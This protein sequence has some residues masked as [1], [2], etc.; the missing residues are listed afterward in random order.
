VNDRFLIEVLHGGHETILEFL[1][2]F[3]PASGRPPCMKRFSTAACLS[4]NSIAVGTKVARFLVRKS[5]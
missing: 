4:Y 1:F 2:S 5:P 3:S